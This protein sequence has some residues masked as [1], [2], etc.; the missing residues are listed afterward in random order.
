MTRDDKK[1][2]VR[3]DQERKADEVLEQT[4]RTAL[5][6]AAVPQAA[7]PWLGTLRAELTKRAEALKP[8]GK[9]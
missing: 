3:R 1:S 5:N 4:L 9:S 7:A 6:K 8:A 2:Q